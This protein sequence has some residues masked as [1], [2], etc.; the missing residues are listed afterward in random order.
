M[1]DLLL[2]YLLVTAISLATVYFLVRFGVKHG[3]RAALR[4]HEM[5]TRDGSLQAAMDAHA[6]K[7]TERAEVQQLEQ[8]A[9]TRQG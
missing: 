2:P 6:A 7:L 8:R 5:W 3:T 1:E 9:A 4:E